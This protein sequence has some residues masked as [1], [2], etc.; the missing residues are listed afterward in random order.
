MGYIPLSYKDFDLWTSKLNH[1]I[2]IIIIIII[3]GL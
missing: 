1:I 2:I 3:I